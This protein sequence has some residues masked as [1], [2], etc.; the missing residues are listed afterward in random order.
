MLGVGSIAIADEGTRPFEAT[1]EWDAEYDVVVVGGGFAGLMTAAAAADAGQRVLVL[2]KAPYAERGGNSRVTCGGWIIYD[3]GNRDAFINYVR[4]V[5]GMYD[6][7]DQEMLEAWADAIVRVPEWMNARGANEVVV[8][9]GIG[10]YADFEGADTVNLVQEDGKTYNA[11]MFNAI[12]RIVDSYDNID[13]WYDTP[14]KRFIQDAQTKIVHGVT[15]EHDGNL[16]NVRAMD[17]VADCAGGFAANNTMVQDYLRFPYAI[18]LGTTYNTGDGIKMATAVG[19]D[20]WH[21]TALD[22][23]DY[24]VENPQTGKAFADGT[25]RIRGHHDDRRE[26]SG[27]TCHNAII[28][29]ADGTRYCDEATLPEHGAENYHGRHIFV[30]MSLPSYIVFDQSAFQYP[31]YPA[32]ET[33]DEQLEN[34]VILKADTLEELNSQLKIA[35]DTLADTV[36]QYNEYCAQGFDPDFGRAAEDLL[37]LET[38]PFYAVEIKPS[39]VN[40]QG[41]PRR[42]GQAQIIDV[43]GNPIPHLYGAGE[44]GSM[45]SDI[46]PGGGNIAEALSFGLIAGENLGK[47]ATDN[48]RESMMGDREPVDFTMQPPTFSAENPNELV[49]MAYGLGGPLWV[50]VTVD[51]KKIAGIE[52]LWNLET[53]G[54]GTK[55]VAQLPAQMV[56]AQSIEVDDFTGATSTSHALKEAVAD[57]LKQGGLL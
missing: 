36:A 40:T 53:P 41:G 50:K 7:P 47:K 52:V 27:F 24:N 8:A 28:V 4:Q 17:G 39:I 57:A 15:V 45:W 6:T 46:Y 11:G 9:K 42:N 49:G 18:A 19:A 29:G 12:S 10:A 20:L 16:Y 1:V 25:I 5:R 23:P 2:E 22:G 55:A 34:G 13:V 43:E 35:Q 48:C 51:G 31:I 54:V 33:N 21:M 37:P 26:S 3:E 44:C 32:W 56:D 14:A 38:G 30:N